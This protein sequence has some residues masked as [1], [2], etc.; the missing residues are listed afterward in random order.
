VKKSIFFLMVTCCF[1]FVLTG[2]TKDEI[3]E[4]YN[5]VLQEAATEA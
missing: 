1:V 4:N 3:I 5:E 2:C